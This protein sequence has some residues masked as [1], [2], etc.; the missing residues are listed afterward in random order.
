VRRRGATVK[1][2]PAGSL[3]VGIEESL[4]VFVARWNAQ[5]LAASIGFI[6][7]APQEIAI[8]VSEL[9][10]NILKYG[11]RGGILMQP[12]HD[13]AHGA[14][15]ELVADDD[16][17]PLFDF[18]VALQDGFGDRGPIDP[19]TLI[20]RGGIGGGL[21]AIAR[22]TDLFEYLPGPPRKSFHAVRY[23]RRPRRAAR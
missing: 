10:T 22:L 18:A 14:G 7:P 8:V 6:G 12:V 5:R 1:P 9:A 17:P 15:L 11:V 20:G 3:R 2:G 23:L 19:G 21:G 16:G 4:D 13:A